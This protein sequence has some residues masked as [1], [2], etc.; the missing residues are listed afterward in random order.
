ML[1]IGLLSTIG[2]WVAFGLRMGIGFAIG[3]AISG[4][5][6]YWLKRAV[7]A[8]ADRATQ[9]VSD[10]NK[11]DSRGAATRF[12]LRYALIGLVA[13]VIFKSSIVSLSSLMAGLFVPVAAI[14]CEAVYET[15]IAL[16][17]GL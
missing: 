11:R 4:L 10:E 13:Y 2:L 16:R 3:C 12:L 5:N 9:A 14:L 8:F 15:F 1:A 17:R 6:F 7:N